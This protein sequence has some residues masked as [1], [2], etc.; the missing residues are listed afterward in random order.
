MN[1]AKKT[2]SEA[3]ADAEGNPV[4][5][6]DLDY[7]IVG[8]HKYAVSEVRKIIPKILHNKVG[9]EDVHVVNTA[10]KG[11]SFEPA[12]KMT[13]KMSVTVDKTKA[14]GFRKAIAALVG[15][16]GRLDEKGWF[17]SITKAVRDNAAQNVGDHNAALRDKVGL[18]AMKV[19]FK[20]FF[21]KS[22][23]EQL[24]RGNVFMGVAGEGAAQKFVFC[25]SVNLKD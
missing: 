17:K 7:R 12:D 8:I 14:K 21:G 15:E 24:E 16:S 1:E 19:Y 25:A 2:E 22:M 20:N 3:E 5:D 11:K 18:E 9:T 6:F 10:I 23:A 13:I 4:G